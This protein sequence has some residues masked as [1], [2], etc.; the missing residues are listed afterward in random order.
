MDISFN[1]NFSARLDAVGGVQNAVPASKAK[2]AAAKPDLTITQSAAAP[3]E[4][5][6]AAIPDSALARDDALGKLVSA[7]FTLPAPPM[8]QFGG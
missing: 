6:A 2:E 5:S 3:E 7:A 1:S 4:V 8:P